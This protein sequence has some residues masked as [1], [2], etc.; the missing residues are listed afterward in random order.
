MPPRADVGFYLVADHDPVDDGLVT[1]GY[2]KVENGQCTEHIEVLPNA[3][4]KSEADALV[5][6]FSGL[7]A[8]LEKIDRA[9]QRA[10]SANGIY[11]HIFFYEPLEAISLQNAVKRHL[12]DSRV[13]DGLLHMVRL[14]PPE[15]VVPEP[16]FRGMHHLPATALRSVL[17]QLYAL[18][19]VVS[20]DLRQ[21]SCAL[22]ERG[23]IAVA[24]SPEAPFRREFSSLLSIEVSRGLRENRS[25]S[26]APEAVENDVRERLQAM[27]AI[28]EWLQ[29]ENRRAM[30]SNDGPM[31]RL[32]KKPFRFH[33]TFD[34]LQA[35][36]L[37]LLRALEL[38]ENRSGLLEALV[39]LAQPI[40]ARRDARRCVAGMRLL[41]SRQ[42]GP[43][44]RM[45]FDAPPEIK[46]PTFGRTLSD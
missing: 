30:E 46:M 27:R 11:S 32:A 3:D 31:L 25:R 19:V 38:L 8:D 2:L 23:L 43:D 18:P 39:R 28:V 37:D 42:E 6:V 34:P 12:D 13:R 4:R 33:A 29:R 17:E 41:T 9:N 5:R 35:G 16:E 45:V 14:F 24:Y 44:Y 36:D 10:D 7:I 40:G 21:V 26:V 22:H 15:E 1:L 20:F